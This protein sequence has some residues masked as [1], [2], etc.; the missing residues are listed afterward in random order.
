MDET[1]I[2][3]ACLA[4]S[5]SYLVVDELFKKKNIK[6]KTWTR[7][8]LLKRQEKGAYN[9]IL[10]KLKLT[11]KEDFQNFRKKFSIFLEPAKQSQ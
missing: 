9:G 1:V 7:D 8:W 11:E 2:I 10:S 6:R 4:A 5:G 3:C